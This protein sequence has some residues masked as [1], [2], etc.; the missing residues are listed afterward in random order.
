[1][2][3]G[4]DA[5][6][7]GEDGEGGDDALAAAAAADGF[8]Q[9]SARYVFSH[10]RAACVWRDGSLQARPA[11]AYAHAHAHAHAYAHAHAHVHAHAQHAH[12][13]EYSRSCERVLTLCVWVGVSASRPPPIRPPTLQAELEQHELVIVAD[14]T[15]IARPMLQHGW[16][17]QG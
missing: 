13:H 5:A 1:M 6:A 14:T 17:G 16:P 9:A 3:R 8:V 2:W 15:P 4:C 7:G 10:A 12:A 11:H